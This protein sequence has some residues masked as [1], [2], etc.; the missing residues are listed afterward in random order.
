[1]GSGLIL[2]ARHSS[3]LC[4]SL[5]ILGDLKDG[6]A[7][8]WIYWQVRTYAPSPTPTPP[9]PASSP[10]MTLLNTS[11][12]RCRSLGMCT[13]VIVRWR[14]LTS[15]IL[16]QPTQLLRLACCRSAHLS[17]AGKLLLH[18]VFVIT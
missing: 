5:Q 17:G 11:R 3:K 15:A 4:M 13:A 16:R 12:L 9:C 18:L 7:Q 1:M 14:M 8:A 10:K 2:P 6:G